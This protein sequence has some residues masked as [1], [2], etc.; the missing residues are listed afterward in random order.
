ML[1]DYNLILTLSGHMHSYQATH[2]ADHEHDL[3]FIVGGALSGH[4]WG[5]D[6]ELGGSSWPE[7]YLLVT[8][9]KRKLEDFEYVSHGWKGYDE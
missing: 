3:Y 8:L 1:A 7:G 5:G 6:H 4:F 2:R 9:K